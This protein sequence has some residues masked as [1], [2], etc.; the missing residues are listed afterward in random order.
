M[1][2]KGA[3]GNRPE[4]MLLAEIIHYHIPTAIVSTEHPIPHPNQV[5]M[6]G[7][8]DLGLH[9][10]IDIRVALDDLVYAIEVNGLI[11]F[12]PSRLK[13]DAL[14]TLWLQTRR[15]PYVTVVVDCYDAPALFA[16]NGGL[17]SQKGLTEAYDQVFDVLSEYFAEY[18]PPAPSCKWLEESKH[19]KPTG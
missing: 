12:E 10:I 9:P 4:Q 7:N 8:N 15:Q 5:D 6:D 16:R 17:L 2:K 13:K 14:R 11:H 18:M 19:R 3:T 1:N